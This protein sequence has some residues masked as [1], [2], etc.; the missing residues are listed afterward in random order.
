MSDRTTNLSAREVLLE[1]EAMLAFIVV[2]KAAKDPNAEVIIEDLVTI[3]KDKL[4]RAIEQI[5]NE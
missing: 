1:V 5:E 4:C 3:A 2:S